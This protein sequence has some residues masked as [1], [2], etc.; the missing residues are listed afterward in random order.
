MQLPSLILLLLQIVITSTNDVRRLHVYPPYKWIAVV[1]KHFFHAL[2]QFFFIFIFLF[3]NFL[4]KIGIIEIHWLIFNGALDLSFFSFQLWRTFLVQ[5]WND[6][7]MAHILFA[8]LVLQLLRYLFSFHKYT[9]ICIYIY[10]YVV[11][12]TYSIICK[13]QS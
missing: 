2:I 13:V 4:S 6:F 8:L 10:E 9:H 1:G 3:L 12:K 7:V 11:V 5:S